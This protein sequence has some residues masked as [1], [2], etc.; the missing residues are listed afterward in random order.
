MS[1][2]I[3]YARDV[4]TDKINGTSGQVID[5]DVNAVGQVLRI[6]SLDPKAV[7]F[8][9]LPNPVPDTTSFADGYVLK[10]TDFTQNEVNW[11]PDIGGGAAVPFILT[12]NNVNALKVQDNSLNTLIRID[13]VDNETHLSGIKNFVEGADDIN[14]FSVL[15]NS[16]PLTPCLNVDSSN[17]ETTIN[18]KL[19]VGGLPDRT[20][21]LEV[22]RSTNGFSVFSVDTLNKQIGLNINEQLKRGYI[23]FLDT[24]EEIYTGLNSSA[25]MTLDSDILGAGNSNFVGYVAKN[26]PNSV[27]TAVNNATAGVFFNTTTNAGIN[28]TSENFNIASF[29]PSGAL[30]VQFNS[31]ISLESNGCILNI[32]NG[33]LIKADKKFVIQDSSVNNLEQFA[34]KD[35]DGNNVFIV[36]TQNDAVFIRGN[37]NSGAKLAIQ[38][39]LGNFVFLVDTNNDLLR[40]GSS[41]VNQTEIIINPQIGII[42]VVAYGSAFF[43]TK[44]RCQHNIWNPLGGTLT[45]IAHRDNTDYN[46]LESIGA[47]GLTI[48]SDSNINMT[49]TNINIT[50]TNPVEFFASCPKTTN[51]PTLDDSLTNKRYVDNKVGG[52][53]SGLNNSATATG[54]LINIGVD[55]NISPTIFLPS[56]PSIPPNYFKA[57]QSFE[58][59]MSGDCNFTNND[60]FLIKL[61]AGLITLGSISITTPTTGASFWELEADFTIR[62]VVGVSCT[63]LTSFDFTFNDGSSFIGKRSLTT[64]VI[65]P[66]VSQTL[67]P[68]INFSVANVASNLKTQMFILK[69]LVDV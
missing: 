36:D 26:G 48:S 12:G 54:A 61:N 63:I 11:E 60:T 6:T 43:N 13:T 57:G 64:A 40:M 3:L 66:T 22:V 15:N 25:Y 33:G 28:T 4:E 14:K 32:G 24:P 59:I 37:D 19:L 9:D 35:V 62:A 45:M 29:N 1:K 27:I 41:A 56:S 18:G 30:S 42:D 21:A 20:D 58:L 10:I 47:N 17:N 7:A 49:G 50:S 69:K 34:V 44:I 2:S 23:K 67:I 51:E 53:S 38:D 39:P 68:Y 31:E 8:Q 5:P 16:D 55:Q 46:K 52:L 65:N